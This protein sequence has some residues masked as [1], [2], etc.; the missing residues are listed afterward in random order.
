MSETENESI[1]DLQHDLFTKAC[2]QLQTVAPNTLSLAFRISLEKPTKR[3]LKLPIMN[4]ISD[5]KDTLLDLL[6][7]LFHPISNQRVSGY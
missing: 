1:K 7:D 5:S 4:T 2:M 6:H 3:S